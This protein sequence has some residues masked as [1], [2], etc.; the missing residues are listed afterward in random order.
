MPSNVSDLDRGASGL[1]F[2]ALTA[3]RCRGRRSMSSLSSPWWFVRHGSAPECCERLPKMA[4]SE[5]DHEIEAFLF[6]QSFRR[7]GNG[8]HRGAA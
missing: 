6:D 1:S 2:S 4:F 8:W 3:A 5:R 7:S